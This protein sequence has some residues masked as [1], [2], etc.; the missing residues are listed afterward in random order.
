MDRDWPLYSNDAVRRLD[1]AA[2]AAGTPAYTLM[3]RAGDAAWRL[4]QRR[5]PDAR[6]LL[7]ACGWGNNGGDGY[8]LAR[9][10]AQAGFDLVV[11]AVEGRAPETD[12]A[13]RAAA[14]WAAVGPVLAW[15]SGDPLPDG[16]VLVDALFGVGLNRPVQGSA[17]TLIAAINAQPAPVL[18]LDVPSGLDAD[19]G[20]APGPAVQA[21]LTL[22][23]VGRKFGLYT[24]AGRALAGE[25]HFD[26]IGIAPTPADPA[27]V[28]RVLDPQRERRQLPARRDDDHKGRFGHV[29]AVGGAAGMGGALRL[30]AEAAAR[31][32]A[33]LVSA[34]GAPEH[35][36][37]LLV[38]RP[39]VMARGCADPADD[40]P[41]QVA[42]RASVLAL[43]PGLGRDTWGEALG[44][45]ALAL[46]LPCVLDADAL[47]H[48][49][50]W[51]RP[52]APCV[53]TPHPAEAARLLG[54]STASVQ[55]D[56]YAAAQ[57]LARQRE[58]VV[59]LKGNGSLVCA[60]SGELH[61]VDAGNP[62]MASG[63]M[64]DVLTGII[65]A[66]LAQGLD[67]F[68]AARLGAL[69]HAEAG[70]R[71]AQAGQRGLLASDVI[72]ALRAEINA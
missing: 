15:H 34:I 33:G 59:V 61:V 23:F 69:L 71:A 2:I 4:L 30:C 20:V 48:L 9:L 38:A 47:W 6:R 19:R 22:S 21:A 50:T 17:A 68:A 43:G 72:A 44:R 25:R 67:A 7:V 3:C 57:L 13:R 35:I 12:A 41:Q 51:P 53:L 14:D 18:A 31:C 62:G 16:D 56:R 45:R 46:G 28:A 60:P 49:P 66:L 70:D 40:W 5:W 54:L 1:A 11:L 58:A 36:V 29:L 42:E 65:A 39:E 63:G 27:P 55:A 52:A 64:G 24:G 10:A 37:A 26:A 32:G 8:V